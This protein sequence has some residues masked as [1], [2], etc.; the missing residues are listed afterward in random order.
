[1]RSHLRTILVVGLAVALVAVFLYNVDVRR[2]AGEIARARPEWLLLSLMTMFVS[3][4]LRALRWQYLLEPLGDASFGNAFRATAVGFAASTLLPARA[5]EVIRPY[6][7]ARHERMSATGA[8]A[9]IILERLLD[10][11]T[12]LTLIAS[13]VF[14]FG[15][16]MAETN[17]AV[18]AALKWA[19]G[20]AALGSCAALAVLFVLAG[21]PAR[22]GRTMARF[23]RALPSVLA[24]LIARIAEK[25]A[26]G[27]GAIR[28]P[29]Q[30]LVALAWSFPLWLTICAG[31]WSVSMAF[32]FA[33]P[34]TGSFLLVAILVV[35]VAVPTPGAVGGFHEA[36][37]LGATMFYG[38][39]D[40]AAVGAAIVLHALTILPSLMLGLFFAAEAG[41]NLS[42]MR[43]LADEAGHTPSV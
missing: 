16:S 9:T 23:E 18:F 38:A 42:G 3:L 10:I 2:A 19:G 4:A 8:F 25:F 7:L 21:D 24:G 1:M 27:L 12:V 17:P 40:A 20:T 36:F 33:M 32:H 39:P 34:F 14:V 37:R 6:F 28:R 43:R 41:L 5:G 30:L 35:G 13:F 26:E 29:G 31:I 22:L 15:R 11:I